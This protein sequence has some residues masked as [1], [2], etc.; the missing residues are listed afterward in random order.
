MKRYSRKRNSNK[1]IGQIGRCVAIDATIPKTMITPNFQLTLW[2][3][4]KCVK[5]LSSTF[6]Q[7]IQRHESLLNKV[8]N[9][10]P[11]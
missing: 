8:T 2:P 10:K 3:E 9:L 11:L 4:T 5:T 1:N 6:L 7:G